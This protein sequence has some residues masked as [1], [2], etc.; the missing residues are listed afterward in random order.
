M[1]VLILLGCLW[2][3][4][5]ELNK[6]T[7]WGWLLSLGLFIAFAVLKKGFLAERSLPLKAGGWVLLLAALAA[8]LLL[9]RGPYLPR[10]AA[11]DASGRTGIVT[12]AQGQLRGVV[13]GW[14]SSLASHTQSPRWESFAGGSHRTPS[15]GRGFWR[16]I[17][18]P[19]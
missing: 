18:T 2:A 17:I 16:R 11:A 8:T 4:V 15:P 19:P 13:T 5:L 10:S 7:L 3:A 6:N 12:V 9:T 14:R 1:V